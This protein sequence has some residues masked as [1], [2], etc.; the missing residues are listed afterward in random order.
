MISSDSIFKSNKIVFCA[1]DVTELHFEWF[2]ITF[3]NIFIEISGKMDILY[4]FR[5]A[6]KVK[7]FK[8]ATY[9]KTIFAV[10]DQ[11]LNVILYNNV[12]SISQNMF[13]IQYVQILKLLLRMQPSCIHYTA[14]KSLYV[15][16]LYNRSLK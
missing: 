5:M 4:Y 14:Y 7:S 12:Y 15:F 9:S 10:N 8:F 3:D 11:C 1:F 2:R 13:C 16:V 6:T